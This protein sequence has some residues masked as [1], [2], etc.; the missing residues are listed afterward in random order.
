MTTVMMVTKIILWLWCNDDGDGNN[1]NGMIMMW[2][3]WDDN[4]DANEYDD[5]DNIKNDDN[6]DDT[7]WDGVE[8]EDND[9]NHIKRIITTLF[10]SEIEYPRGCDPCCIVTMTREFEQVI[11]LHNSWHEEETA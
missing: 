11:Q 3:W 5:N 10:S 4:D 1:D 9:L 8:E 7:C 2:W 6:N